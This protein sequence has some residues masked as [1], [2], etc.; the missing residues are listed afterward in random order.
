MEHYF[1]T[2]SA[3]FIGFHLAQ[4]LLAKGH[5]VIGL[6]NLNPYYSVSLK[7]ARNSILLENHN[8]TFFKNDL[9]EKEI[10]R[11]IFS[12][13]PIRAVF[14]IAAQ[15]GVRYS[16]ENPEVYLKS[17]IEGTLCI[18]EAVRFM[19]NTPHI[20]MASS[21]SV[22]GLTKNYPFKEE[23]PA[24]EPISFYGATKRANELMGYTYSHLF[25]LK[26]TMMRFFT[27]YGPWGRP[28]MAPFKFVKSAVENKEIEVFNQGNMIRDFTYIDDII[29]G[30][31]S[32]NKAR[33][34]VQLPLFDIFNIGCSK[35]RTLMEFI[36]SIE[37]VLE[38]KIKQKLLPAQPGD[39][40]KTYA[41]ITKI[42]QFCGY[43]PKV[44]LQEG[45]RS[46][47]HWYQNF[48]K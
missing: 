13:Y 9:C 35:P 31:L 48:Y 2:G 29:D 43:S 34:N 24:N 7:E 1:V 42:N 41:D 30:I 19:K 26:I 22:Y 44:S 39:V 46:F 11:K 36:S 18:L 8:Y 23:D 47:I 20:F 15:A 4:K 14:H 27:V 17:N 40:D 21:S 32:L 16:L 3:G 38:K 6:D 5:K 10:I 37:T 25:G 33:I 28:D 45:M 12:Q